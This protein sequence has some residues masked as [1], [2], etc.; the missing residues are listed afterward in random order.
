[1]EFE[2]TDLTLPTGTSTFSF[3]F[4]MTG[5]SLP[6]PFRK[7]ETAVEY[8]IVGY[9][10]H[11]SYYLKMASQPVTYNGHLN[12][13]SDPPVVRPLTHESQV[14]VKMSLF[15]SITLKVVL[16]VEESSFLPGEEIPFQFQ[17]LCRKKLTIENLTVNLIRKSV[18]N[19]NGVMKMGVATLDVFDAA[20]METDEGQLSLIVGVLRIPRTCVPSYREKGPYN[21]IHL[22]EVY[23]TVSTFL[24]MLKWQ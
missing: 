13:Y 21:V 12:L 8:Q 10:R 15:S 17:L 5:D 1:L 14:E 6:A 23:I 18:Y 24:Y 2:K 9:I 20:E 7:K 19:I 11:A 3:A 4:Q 22:L 16:S